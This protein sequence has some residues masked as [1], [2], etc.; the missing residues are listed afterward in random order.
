MVLFA[1]LRKSNGNFW[2]VFLQVG[3][4]FVLVGIISET[5]SSQRPT[6]PCL[7][8]RSIRGHAQPLQNLCIELNE[9]SAVLCSYFVR[10][11]HTCNGTNTVAYLR[12]NL[13]RRRQEPVR[14]MERQSKSDGAK[15]RRFLIFLYDVEGRGGASEGGGETRDREKAT[16]SAS[17]RCHHISFYAFDTELLV[18]DVNV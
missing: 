6:A 16:K 12:L 4:L 15:M 17:E 14:S 13:S 9:I 1:P 10:N 2:S 18:H 7:P 11:T 3:L 8:H 5:R